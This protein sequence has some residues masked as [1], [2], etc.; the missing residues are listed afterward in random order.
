[1]KRLC[2]IRV[3]TFSGSRAPGEEAQSRSEDEDYA[4]HTS[5]IN[6][7]S[8]MT[9]FHIHSGYYLS[10]LG[11]HLRQESPRHSTSSFSSSSRRSQQTCSVDVE[12]LL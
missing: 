8:T 3:P 10:G 7:F 4:S 12:A 2:K 6:P 9:R 11:H 1:M 5:W